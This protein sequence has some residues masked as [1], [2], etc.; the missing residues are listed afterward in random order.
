[1]G[2]VVVTRLVWVPAL[3]YLP[4]WLFRRIREHD[5]YPPI[6]YPIVISWAGLRGA[7]SLAAALALPLTTHA[8]APFGDRDLIVFLAFCVILGTLVVQGLSLPALIR[9]LRLEDDGLGEREEAKARIKA[10]HAALQR[11]EELA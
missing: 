9:A 11:L 10:A 6:S 5:P 2:A 3:A 1:T 4:R 7:V 8:G